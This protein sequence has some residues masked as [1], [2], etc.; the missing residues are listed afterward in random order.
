MK[1][2]IIISAL[3]FAS[4]LSASALTLDECR[5]MALESS[6]SL[7][8]EQERMAA[9]ESVLQSTRAL[10]LPNI[11]AR[12]AYLYS[13]ATYDL[14]MTGGMLPNFA[15]DT[16]LGS[17]VPD[18]T[19]AYM[20]D[21]NYELK[22]GSIYTG[23]LVA[24]QPIYMGRKV[25]NAIKLAKVG[26]EVSKLSS[27]KSE[28]EVIEE[29][30]NA[31]YAYLKLLEMQESA[32]AYYA[33]VEEFR[34]EVSNVVEQGLAHRNDL[35][36]VE[37]EL[38]EAELAL[39]KTENG[40]RLARMNLCYLIGK[41][42]TTNDLAVEDNFDSTLTI[43]D[44]SLDITARPEYAL[45]E[46][47]IRAK[48]L[49]VELTK[50]NYMPSVAALSSYGYG[51]AGTINGADFLRGSSF[52]VGVVVSVPIFGWGEG[53]NKV[54]ASRREV[55]IARNTFEDASQKMSLELL[56]ALNHYDESLLE[57]RLCLTSLDQAEESMRLSKNRYEAGME[58]LSDYLESQAVWHRAMSRLVDA[59]ASQ[60]VAYTS[61][62]RCRGTISL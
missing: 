46:H 36:K 16:S 27:K 23:S 15:F 62:E 56:N 14:T 53:R 30:D 54:A 41:P 45:L 51:S 18:G 13:T 47:Q 8:S 44:R 59:R 6:R 29:C 26:V 34:H 33:V 3:L 17:L 61:Y 11:S 32:K 1:F 60:R 57:V 7:K 10:A 20:P 49:G 4:T 39:L 5:S 42:L 19:Y 55:S 38:N 2:P 12:G 52:N 40:V 21:Q 25:S 24:T 9:S 58:K 48:E 22:A 43:S 37:V 50:A 35:L 28:A 31:F